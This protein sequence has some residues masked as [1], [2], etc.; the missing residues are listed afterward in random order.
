MDPISPRQIEAFKAIVETASVTAAAASMHVSQ[1]SVSRLLRSL[2]EAIGFDLFERR[3]GRLLAT[4]EAMLFYDEIQKYFRNVQRLAHTAADIRALARGQL[5][6]GTFIAFAVAV[7]P[8]AIKEFNRAHPQMHVSCTTA[9]SRQIVDM[10]SSRF[11]DLGIVDPIAA[12][13]G[14]RIERQWKFRCVCAVPAEHRLAA[15]DMIT[16]TE[17]AS[18]NVIGLEREFLS[19]YAPGAKL[20]ETLAPALRVQVHQ[21]IA[22]CA[23]VAEGVGVA[24]VDPFTAMHCEPRGIVVRPLEVTIPFEICIVAS[25]EAPLSVAA[26]EFLRI[27]DREM[28]AACR[29]AAYV[30]S[31]R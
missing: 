9:Q 4:P 18:E 7:T 13:S 8:S 26:Q 19:R 6:L 20:Y 24:V 5:R 30:E 1:P 21:S 31:C 23:L 27:F 12:T 17:L 22:A 11:A 2:E 29:A 10:I 3:K 28:H 25:P 16:A 15:S 14:V